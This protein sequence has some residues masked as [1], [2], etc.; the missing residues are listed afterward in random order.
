[1]KLERELS[2]SRVALRRSQQKEKDLRLSAVRKRTQHSKSVWSLLDRAAQQT[3]RNPPLALTQEIPT[4]GLER[5]PIGLLRAARRRSAKELGSETTNMRGRESKSMFP[6]YV[7]LNDAVLRRKRS[8]VSRR[9]AAELPLQTN[10]ILQSPSSM[11]LRRRQKQEQQFDRG[12][13]EEGEREVHEG[14]RD[15]GGRGVRRGK[16][17]TEWEKIMSKTAPPGVPLPLPVFVEQE[18]EEMEDDDGSWG[19]NQGGG[20]GGG[21]GGEGD[22][23]EAE[24]KPEEGRNKRTLVSQPRVMT[25]GVGGDGPWSTAY[26][27]TRTKKK[28]AETRKKEESTRGDRESS[29]SS[30]SNRSNRS[31]VFLSTIGNFQTMEEI[32]NI[33]RA[34]EVVEEEEESESRMNSSNLIEDERR[35]EMETASTAS[36]AASNDSR[37]IIYPVESHLH[38]SRTRARTRRVRNQ[39]LLENPYDMFAFEIKEAGR[40]KRQLLM[41]ILGSFEHDL[42]EIEKKIERDENNI[43]SPRMISSSLTAL[44]REE[45]EALFA[46]VPSTSIILTRAELQQMMSNFQLGKSTDGFSFLNIQNTM[47]RL[48]QR[49]P[50]YRGG[51]PRIDGR[52]LLLSLRNMVGVTYP[53]AKNIH[54]LKKALVRPIPLMARAPPALPGS[55]LDRKKEYQVPQRSMPRKDRSKRRWDNDDFDATSLFIVPI[56][57]RP[58]SM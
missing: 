40:K 12:E 3:H 33:P 31:N 50:T 52:R 41:E 39:P 5:D 13:G 25:H 29:R 4:L 44:V 20:G 49:I 53:E 10:V 19:R 58:S 55:K 57:A 42:N 43:K 48:I 18:M 17:P 21:G 27:G 30:K 36:E 22:S 46:D 8:S 6:K 45:D 24:E 11:A 37:I 56:L 9:P 26:P 54:A 35:G 15:G 7:P 51:Q 2:N 23:N 16:R 28:L 14:V 47:N 1:M 34:R 38:L 32:S